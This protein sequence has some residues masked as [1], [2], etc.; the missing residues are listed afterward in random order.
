[1]SS[2]NIA[3]IGAHP[4]ARKAAAQALGKKATAQDVTTYTTIFQGK[5][6][7]I[8]EPSA[9]PE[10]PTTLVMALNAADY[11]VFL[12]DASPHLGEMLVALSRLSKSH[13]CV[14]GPNDVSAYLTEANLRYESFDGLAAAKSH[15]LSQEAAHDTTAPLKAWVDQSFDVKGVGPVALGWVKQGTLHVHDKLSVWP[16]EKHIEV[17]SIQENDVDVQKAEAG[18]R[19]GIRFKGLDAH[20]LSRGNVLGEAKAFHEIE[21]SVTVPK[22]L[23][24]PPGKALHAVVGLQNVPC[25]VD[26]ELAPGTTQECLVQ[27]SKPVALKNDVLTLLDLNADRLRIAGV[28]HEVG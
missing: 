16:Q 8:V 27:F 10:K 12:S 28:A 18:D 13:G 24:Q 17:R 22:Y 4:D 7:T 26:Q 11:V 14:V 20:E 21:A 23:K 19:F 3:V 25:T 6:V 9:Y 1:M 15:I 2:L 5:N